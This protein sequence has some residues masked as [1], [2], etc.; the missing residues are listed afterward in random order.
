MSRRN[1]CIYQ[2]CCVYKDVSNKRLVLYWHLW[3][4]C[5][6]RE[7]CCTPSH[8]RPNYFFLSLAHIHNVWRK[9]SSHLVFNQCNFLQY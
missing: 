9:F 1:S 4:V 2:Y 8:P 7:L 3:Q 5:C 6:G